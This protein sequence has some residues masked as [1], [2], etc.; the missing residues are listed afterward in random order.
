[1]NNKKYR[2]IEI[3]YDDI[4]LDDL[5]KGAGL[6]DVLEFKDLEERKLYLTGEV[7]TFNT[8]DIIHKILQYNADDRD[9]PVEERTPIRLYITSEGGD[10]QSGFGLIDTIKVSKTPVYT[11]NIG[12]WYSMA[13]LIGLA[14]HKRY[15][16]A[17]A[18][19]LLHDG[20]SFIYNSSNKVQDQMDFFKK[21]EARIKDH[22]LT[23]TKVTQKMYEKKARVEWYMLADEARDLGFVDAIIGVDCDLDEVL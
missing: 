18:S 17:N 10:V 7:G 19:I 20:S 1:M 22:V 21:I 11:I 8:S 3:C 14:G 6:E 9:I 23:H 13:L 12:Y 2:G 4:D 15:A 16:T 5:L